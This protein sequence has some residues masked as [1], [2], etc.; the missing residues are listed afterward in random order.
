MYSVCV[1]LC[2]CICVRVCPFVCFQDLSSAM[3]E[4]EEL[5]AQLCKQKQQSQQTAQ[6]LEQL[7]KV[8][9]H[10][11]TFFF[12]ITHSSSETSVSEDLSS[13]ATGDGQPAAMAASHKERGQL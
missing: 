2:V 13:Q 4:V 7:R 10:T 5:T 8:Y 12:S 1:Y 11:H 6:E 9:T 3:K